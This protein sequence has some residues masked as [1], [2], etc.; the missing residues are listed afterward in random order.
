MT[1]Q[2][3]ETDG[4]ATVWQRVRPT[5]LLLVGLI[6]CYLGFLLLDQ[7]YSAPTSVQVSPGHLDE[8]SVPITRLGSGILLVVLG[9]TIVIFSAIAQVVASDKIEIAGKIYAE[10]KAFFSSSFFFVLLGCLF[11]YV[12]SREMVNTHSAFVFLLAILGVAILL[13]GTGTQAAGTAKTDDS[14]LGAINLYIAGGA[15]VLA[16]VFGWGVVHYSTDIQKVF[17][18]NLD[19]GV[20]ELT[21]DPKILIY[22]DIAAEQLGGSQLHLLKKDNYVQ[23]LVPFFGASSQSF[24]KVNLVQKE[25]SSLAQVK[26]LERN[27]NMYFQIA[28]T[29]D[30]SVKIT[31]DTENTQ[32]ALQPINIEKAQV[33]V[34]SGVNNEEIF[35]IKHNLI[36]AKAAQTVVPRNNDN[37]VLEAPVQV[38]PQ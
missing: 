26:E 14:N 32:T 8:I 9:L 7:I 21:G 1:L 35:W 37:K 3:S 19:Y 25:G 18:R 34:R 4:A 22:Y 15:G 20:I 16:A 13:Y 29:A 36:F 12:A 2:T 23:I 27:F 33:Q 17:K 10:V 24:A 38:I 28:W 31:R 11:L 6:M 30:G 5:V